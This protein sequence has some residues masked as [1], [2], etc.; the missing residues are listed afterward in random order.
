VGYGFEI[1]IS[2]LSH[3]ARYHPTYYIHLTW[4]EILPF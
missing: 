4:I 1:K 2:H 3:H